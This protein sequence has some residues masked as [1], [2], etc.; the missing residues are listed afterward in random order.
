MSI[1]LEF[2]DLTN[3]DVAYSRHLLPSQEI[4]WDAEDRFVLFSGGLGCIGG[5]TDIGGKTVEQRWREGVPFMVKDGNGTWS[6]ALPPVRYA[7][8]Q[9]YRVTTENSSFVSTGDHRVRTSHGFVFVKELSAGQQLESASHLPDS[10]AVSFRSILFLGALHLTRKVLDFRDGCH[11]ALRSCGGQLLSVSDIFQDVSPSPAYAL[12]RTRESF[13]VDDSRYESIGIRSCRRS[14]RLSMRGYESPFA[15]PERDAA[16]RVSSST[17]VRAFLLDQLPPL[18]LSMVFRSVVKVVADISQSVS[19]LVFAPYPNTTESIISVKPERFDT[20]YNFHVVGTHTYQLGL[21]TIHKNCGKSMI[22]ILKVIYECMSQPNNYFLLGRTS[23]QE[24]HDVLLKEFFEICHPSW[25]KSYTKSPHP[26]VVLHTFSGGSSEIIFRNLDKDSRA[27]ILGLNLGG[28]G[29]DQAEDVPEE[30]VLT[31]K[32]RLRRQGIKHRGYMTSNPK[33]SW[34][35]RAFKQHPE[36]GHRLI[37]ASTL[38]NEK[39]LPPEYV[40][41]LLNYPKSWVKQYVH[42]VWDESLLSDNIV[43]AREFI[44]RLTRYGREPSEIKEGLKIYKKYE[45]GHHYQIGIDCAEG[46]ELSAEVLRK[47]AKDSA[48][49]KIWDLTNDEE[50]AHWSAK[51]APRVTAEK[52]VLFAEWYGKPEIVPEMNSMGLALIDKLDD[53]GYSNVYRRKEFDRTTKKTMKKVGWRTTASSKQLL[54][55]HFEELCRK[56]DPKIYSRTTV[57]EMKT[58]VYSDV[59]SKKGAGALEGFH[60]DEVMALLL[61]SFSEGEVTSRVQHSS[62]KHRGILGVATVPTVTM[63]NGMVVPPH[64][65]F[66]ERRVAR[67]ETL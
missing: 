11:R 34:L 67:F 56:R 25:I 64:M 17:A 59:A 60:D 40:K 46:A 30:V 58:F 13:C 47:E 4:F 12:E 8:T 41:D 6:L 32:G 20:Y 54:I 5:E 43:F 22:L 63:K 7:P 27:E 21:T 9:L 26:S 23:Y 19:N 29:I 3:G 1:H 44:E 36:E 31:L 33:L 65:P 62:D 16:S 24:I 14:R 38:E 50:V 15:E 49:I 61:A 37:E 45:K 53:L 48:V 66:T 51:V 18:S 39:N 2:K 35:Y 57:E 28:F 10:S 55:S 52:A 42:G